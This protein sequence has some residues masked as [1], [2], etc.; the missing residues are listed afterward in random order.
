MSFFDNFKKIQKYYEENKNFIEKLWKI[1]FVI[2]SFTFKFIF[3]DKD[4][5]S[6]KLDS[7]L[8]NYIYTDD[9]QEV[10]NIINNLL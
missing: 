9:L 10:K 5:K 4:K 6:I 2:F 3:D 8:F 1:Y 7:R